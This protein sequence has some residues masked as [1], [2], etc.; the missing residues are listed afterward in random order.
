MRALRGVRYWLAGTGAL[1]LGCA[2]AVAQETAAPPAPAAAAQR[3]FTPADFARFAPSTALDMLNNLPGFSANGGEQGRG[4]GQA[5]GNVLV[6]GERLA[7]KSDDVFTQLER[8]PAGNVVRIELVDAASLKVPGLSG[9]VANVVTRTDAFSGQF[10]WRPEV[11]AHYAHPLFTRGSVSASGKLGRAEY[12]LSL[13]NEANRGA[14]GGPTTIRDG[15]GVV[16]ERREDVLTSDRDAPK[17]SGTLKFPGPLGG[18]GNLNASYQRIWSRDDEVSARDSVAGA[19]RTRTIRSREGGWNYE[20]GG[21]YALPAG[22]GTLKLIGL[23]RRLHEP[24]EQSVIDRFAAPTAPQGDFY[25]QVGE[26]SERIVR[27]EYSWKML[28][29]DWQAAGE[30]AFNRL[31]NVAFTGDLGADGRFIEVPYADATGGVKEDRYDASLSMSR[32]LTPKLSLQTIVAVER[33]TIAQTSPGGL[34]RRFVR[35]KGS[36]SL[37]WKPEAGLDLS[38]KLQRRIGQLSFYDFLARRFVDTGNANAANAELRPR[39]DWTLELEGSKSLGKWGSVTVHA[40]GRAVT[41]YVT[42]IPL[43]DGGEAVGNVSPARVGF[44]EVTATLQLEALGWKGAKLDAHGFIQR[45]QYRDRLTGQTISF[46]NVGEG[47]IDANLRHDVPGTP[48]A[49]GAGL[50]WSRQSL[51]YRRSEYGRDFEGPLFTSLFV[52]HKDVFGLTVR[53]SVF[54]LTNGRRRW[55]RVVFTGDRD[56]SPIKFTETRNQLIGP[57][58]TLRVKGTF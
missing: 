50:E 22:P 38:L 37:A 44:A 46:N 14:A 40:I 43:P 27:A 58:F 26:R 30:G 51:S 53:A 7:S 31:S 4:L 57:I 28:G 1:A 54:N 17:L 2:P 42:V 15:A 20:I 55:D 9:L 33:S 18:T 49:W 16:T 8:I 45:G 5:S 3:V 25:R 21:D 32:A 48:W 39:Q 24:Y 12:T 6:N 36:V 52:E 47:G 11:R 10:E 34:V 19:D 56:L 35:P 29:S 41:D 23:T 13:A